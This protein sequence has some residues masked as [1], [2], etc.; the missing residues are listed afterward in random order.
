[1]A[2]QMVQEKIYENEMVLQPLGILRLAG[3]VVKLPFALIK[4]FAAGVVVGFRIFAD[5][6]EQVGMPRKGSY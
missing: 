3:S 6:T 1:M 2:Q 4:G 5:T